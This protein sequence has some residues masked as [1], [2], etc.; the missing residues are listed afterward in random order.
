MII[1]CQ[2]RAGICAQAR[3]RARVY[4]DRGPEQL[5]TAADA[6]RLRASALSLEAARVLPCTASV[7]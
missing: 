4:L 5:R 2:T 1:D 3:V 6:R 7:R